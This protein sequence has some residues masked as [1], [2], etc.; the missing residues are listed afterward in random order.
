MTQKYAAY[1]QELQGIAVY[2]MPDAQEPERFMKYLQGAC[3]RL[4]TWWAPS[5]ALGGIVAGQSRGQ[6][7]EVLKFR[8]LDAML[9]AG[10]LWIDSSKAVTQDD[11]TRIVAH[12]LGHALFRAY[13]RCRSLLSAEFEAKQKELFQ[14]LSALGYAIPQT[15]LDTFFQEIGYKKM[16]TWMDGIVLDV[17]GLTSIDEYFATLFERFILGE[18]DKIRDVSKAFTSALRAIKK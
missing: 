9:A 4:G 7:F 8:D 14:K 18:K 10:Y 2:I 13:P 3:R 1:F 5:P 6:S 12:E 11:V 15:S 16:N 17:Y